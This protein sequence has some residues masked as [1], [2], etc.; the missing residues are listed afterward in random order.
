MA[1][2]VLPPRAVRVELTVGLSVVRARA[3]DADGLAL[4]AAGLPAGERVYSVAVPRAPLKALAAFDDRGRLVL[5]CQPRR[6][7]QP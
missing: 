4:G 6:C 2:G 3:I 5:A 1:F 7:I